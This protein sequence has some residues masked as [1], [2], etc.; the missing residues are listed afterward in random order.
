MT[1][2][3]AVYVRDRDYKTPGMSGKGSL[4]N[5]EYISPVGN[6]LAGGQLMGADLLQL[7]RENLP[8]TYLTL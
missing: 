6:N 4:N 2:S 5:S 7:V 1:S 3:D 8:L